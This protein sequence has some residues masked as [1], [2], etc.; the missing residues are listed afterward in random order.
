MALSCG[1][2]R[3]FFTLA[4]FRV[5]VH[6]VSAAFGLRALLSSTCRHRSGAAGK[7]AGLSSIS[8]LA[9]GSSL[10]FTHQMLCCHEITIGRRC[11]NPLG[12]S[13][14]PPTLCVPI[15]ERRACKR[16]VCYTGFIVKTLEQAIA[17][18][19]TLPDADQEQ[20]GLRLLSHVKKTP[21]AP[22]GDR[23]GHPLA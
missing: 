18:V 12:T 22:R 8:D 10:K 6:G 9:K 1:G 3:F 13:E 19:A 4:R 5:R 23:Q 2:E 21:S 15:R 17:E 16:A 14:S 20:I 7:M 11:Q